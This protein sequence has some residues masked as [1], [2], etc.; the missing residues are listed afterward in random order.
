MNVVVAAFTS[1]NLHEL[2]CSVSIQNLSN[3]FLRIQSLAPVQRLF[4]SQ[5]KIAS[6]GA[7]CQNNNK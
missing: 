1:N 7:F 6:N 2:F 4:P 3:V 5:T